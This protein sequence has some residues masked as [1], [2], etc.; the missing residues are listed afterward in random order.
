MAYTHEPYQF[1]EWVLQG[2]LLES[3]R[4]EVM[5]LLQ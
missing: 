5:S 3:H 2:V 4:G 1:R